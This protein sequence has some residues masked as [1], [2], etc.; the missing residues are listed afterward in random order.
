[1][2][3]GNP[4][5][6]QQAWSASHAQVS[7]A[8]Y[9]QG[10]F[11]KAGSLKPPILTVEEVAKVTLQA[12]VA[13]TVGLRFLI[14]FPVAVW[15]VNNMFTPTCSTSLCGIC[16]TTPCKRNPADHTFN[17]SPGY[18]P[19][20][21]CG[22]LS[23]PLARPSVRQAALNYPFVVC[24]GCAGVKNAVLPG[25]I[26]SMDSYRQ[27]QTTLGILDMLGRRGALFMSTSCDRIRS[28]QPI[29]AGAEAQR[30]LLDLLSG[31]GCW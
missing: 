8:P 3:Y 29:T 15:P 1:M 10:Y 13:Q 14:F 7:D 9:M 6:W 4:T 21:K 12:H 25:H 19:S 11:F 24:Q 28:S 31:P 18:V 27:T 30:T 22:A 20:D 17:V 5:F 26:Q 23:A 16:C 2:R